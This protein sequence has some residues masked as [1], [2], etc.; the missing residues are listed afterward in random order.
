MSKRT[1]LFVNEELDAVNMYAALLGR[2]GYDV[3]KCDGAEAA[4]ESAAAL[5]PHAIVTELLEKTERG[6][7]TPQLLKR[8]KR[9][10]HIPLIVLTAWTT[11]DDRAK[12][13]ASGCDLFLEKPITPREL[14]VRLAKLFEV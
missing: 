1:V 8:D 11:A 13:E 12:A 7:R 2:I 6:W 9:V 14:A 5:N 10:R 3:F 4:V